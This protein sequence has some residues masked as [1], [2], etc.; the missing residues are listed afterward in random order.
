M[1]MTPDRGASP[2]CTVVT[3]TDGEQTPG[4]SQGHAYELFIL[5]LTV[6]SLVVS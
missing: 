5:V 6:V 3:P 2:S 1:S 4:P